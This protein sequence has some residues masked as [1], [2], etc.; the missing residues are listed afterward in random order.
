MVKR[1]AVIIVMCLVLTVSFNNYSTIET[2]PRTEEPKAE[3]FDGNIDLN[4]AIYSDYYIDRV[5]TF[6]NS[7]CGYGKII[8][9]GDSITDICEW[10][11]L[12]NNPNVLNR[13]ISG[14]TT[15]GVINRLKEVI[16]LKPS[17]I[18]IMLGINDIGKCR[19]NESII[20]DYKKILTTIKRELPGT[21]IYV[22]SV[23]PINKDKFKTHTNDEEII[24]FN[25][26][27]I[28]L[29]RESKIYYVD[30]YSKFV[31]AG[32]KLNPEFTTGGLHLNGKGYI[33]WK[34]MIED[35]CKN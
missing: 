15:D 11:E 28:K 35:L 16:R 6:M 32:N 14:D 29:C 1:I 2:Y 25:A 23:L 24:K 19:S 10:S 8:F 7:S 33:V 20:E 21:K 22:Q 5:T 34:E 31:T 26:E 17:K 30:L 9:L 12:L 4:P 13:G 18:F 27:L 3:T